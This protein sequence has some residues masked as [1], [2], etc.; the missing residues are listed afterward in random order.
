MEKGST[1]STIIIIA[2]LIVIIFLLIVIG[3]EIIGGFSGPAEESSTTINLKNEVLENEINEA[4]Y[5]NSLI[6]EEE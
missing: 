6:N 5:N 2:L 3:S 4:I 1:I